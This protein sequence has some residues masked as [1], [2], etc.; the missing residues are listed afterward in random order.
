LWQK[1]SP[2]GAVGRDG[3]KYYE[4]LGYLP[5]SSTRGEPRI[6][7]ATAKTLEYAYDDFCAA[8]LAKAIGKTRP[9]MTAKPP[10]KGTGTSWIFR[11]PGSSMRRRACTSA[12]K[13]AVRR[14][15]PLQRPPRPSH[16]R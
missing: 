13:L 9:V 10:A 2:M 11:C 4:D 14:R 6:S 16:K 15:S 7:E 1:K 12:A 5:Y 8:Q 3:A